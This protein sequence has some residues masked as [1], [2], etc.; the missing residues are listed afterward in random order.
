MGKPIE[1]RINPRARTQIHR[2]EK[3]RITPNRKAPDGGNSFLRSKKYPISFMSWL[4]SEVSILPE[5]LRRRSWPEK[6][7]IDDIR[8]IA[9]PVILRCIIRTFT[10]WCIWHI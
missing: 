6:F 10:A 2:A 3:R 7:T 5:A 1:K 4:V 9:K 8:I